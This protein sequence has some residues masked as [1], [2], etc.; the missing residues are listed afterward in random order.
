MLNHPNIP[1]Y[2]VILS[3]E[4]DDPTGVQLI[5]FVESPATGSHFIALSQNAESGGTATGNTAPEPAALCLRSEEKQVLTGPVLIPDA[6]LLRKA[7]DGRPFYV[8]FS[9]QVIE[10][11]RNKF[12]RSGAIAATSDEHSQPLH[13]NHIVESWLVENP[14]L[15]K[16]QAIGLGSLPKGTWVVSYKINDPAYWN[17]EIKSGKRKGFS[18]EGLFRLTKTAE[19][20]FAGLLSSRQAQLAGQPSAVPMPVPASNPL[21]NPLPRPSNKPLSKPTPQPKPK[22]RTN[23]GSVP[24]PMKL[25][26]N[27]LSLLSLNSLPETARS[28][29]APAATLTDKL[30]TGW[31]RLRAVLAEAAKL[32]EESDTT[33]ENAGNTSAESDPATPQP[34]TEPSPESGSETANAPNAAL[35]E[36]PQQ[37]PEAAEP[38]LTDLARQ[39]AE[40]LQQNK[41]LKQEMELLRQE[42]AAIAATPAAQPLENERSR[43]TKAP[44]LADAYIAELR[45]LKS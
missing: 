23:P 9:A 22:P 18:L 11:I 20:L 1:V 17:R 35:A 15:D 31:L 34:E 21:Q 30:Q 28:G 10:Q 5:S 36:Q 43:Q 25:P 29:L 41:Q 8:Q 32:F 14:E 44:N 38:A 2:K 4:A 12:F 24:P 37:N 27:P 40:V 7:P 3:D 33:G 6:L 19:P 16:A 13:H 42:F 45:R 26:A 39:A